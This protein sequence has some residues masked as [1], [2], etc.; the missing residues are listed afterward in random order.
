GP[1]VSDQ[2]LGQFLR[3]RFGNELVDQLLA[4]LITGIYSS[5]VDDKSFM[6]S[7]SHFFEF[8]TEK[9]RNI[10]RISEGL[11]E[12]REGNGNKEGQFVS[13]QGGLTTVIEALEKELSSSI[14]KDTAIQKIHQVNGAYTLYDNHENVYNADGVILATPHRSVSSMFEQTEALTALD[15]IPVT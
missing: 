14:Q 9:G 8:E 11:P 2:S 13:V 12:R 7:F 4:P 15:T 10:K 6:K 5:K 3:R 1:S